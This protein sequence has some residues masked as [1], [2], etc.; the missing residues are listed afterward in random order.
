MLPVLTGLL[1]EGEENGEVLGPEGSVQLLNMSTP[2]TKPIASNV[3]CFI[4]GRML[5][6]FLLFPKKI[7]I[8]DFFF[9]RKYLVFLKC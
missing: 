7:Q 2:R 1:I 8:R 6:L 4:K 5:E 3:I 9:W